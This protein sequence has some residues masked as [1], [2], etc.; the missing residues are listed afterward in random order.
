M[1]PPRVPIRHTRA[2]RAAHHR[3]QPKLHPIEPEMIK[4]RRALLAFGALCA[5]AAPAFAQPDG[6]PSRP[7]TIVVGYPPGGSTDLVGRVVAEEMAKVLK[8]TVVVENIGGAGGALGAQKVVSAKPD[9]YTLLVGVNNEIVIA[10][11]INK[12]LKYKGARDLEPLALLAGQPL[13]LVASP[14]AKVR[15]PAEFVDAVKKEPGKHAFGSSGIGTSLHLLGELVKERAGLDLL[16]V[17]Y[18]GVAPLTTDLLGGNIN[19]GIFVMSSALPHI[20]A[21]KL[22]PIGTSEAKRSSITPDIPA[23][24]EHPAMKGI[25]LSSWFMLAGPKGMP[26]DVVAKLRAAAQ[27]ALKSPVVRQKLQDAGATVPAPVADLQKF[28]VSETEKF[29]RIAESAK[30]EQ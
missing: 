20:K 2:I 25:D 9:G 19:Y 4:L 6:Y 8:G 28:M 3:P 7:I 21:G 22:V 15:T 27:E 29:R 5:C 26:A 30:I 10:E 24:A 17:P 23:L 18:R 14:V 12:S 11:S 13:V 16:H 1:P